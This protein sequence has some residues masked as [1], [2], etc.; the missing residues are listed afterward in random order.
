M[1]LKEYQPGTTFPGVVGRTVAESSPAWPEPNRAKE[2]SPNVIF[3]VLDDD[4]YGQM[5]IFG[6][7]V[8]TPTFDQLASKLTG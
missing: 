5:S 7:L 1:A 4:G 8:N 2:G 3:I 6:G